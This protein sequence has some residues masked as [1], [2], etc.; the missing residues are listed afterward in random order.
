MWELSKKHKTYIICADYPS[1][2]KHDCSP[3]ESFIRKVV[4]ATTELHWDIAVENRT[5]G[6][7]EAKK[8]SKR[9]TQK[10]AVKFHGRKTYL[11]QNPPTHAKS[12]KLKDVTK[13][14][15][16]GK[17]GCRELAKQYST[18]LNLPTAMGHETAK[19]MAHEI[20]AA[21]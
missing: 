2:F 5:N 20:V 21:K 15:K 13:K 14:Y 19:R 7:K 17:F 4:M 12:M 18:V 10:G 1:L 11:L 6:P 8:R 3:A 16:A 9:K